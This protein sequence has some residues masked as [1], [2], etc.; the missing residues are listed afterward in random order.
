MTDDTVKLNDTYL[1]VCFEG[2]TVVD[3]GKTSVSS[4]RDGCEHGDYESTNGRSKS[5][6][7]RLT[8]YK[9]KASWGLSTA[10]LSS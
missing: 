2:R 5:L 3:S 6:P 7:I 4:S 10:L 8:K 1:E 9:D